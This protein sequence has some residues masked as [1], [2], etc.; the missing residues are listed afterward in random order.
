MRCVAFLIALSLTSPALAE[1]REVEDTVTLNGKKTQ[2]WRGF[3]SNGTPWYVHYWRGGKKVGVHVDFFEDGGRRSE[4][5]YRGDILNGPFKTWHPTGKLAAQGIHRD[6]A[7]DGL[8]EAF[9]LDGEPAE[10]RT[11]ADTLPDGP[12]LAWHP[13]GSK[14]FEG[15]FAKGIPVGAWQHWSP[16]GRLIAERRF[17]AG[18]L[19]EAPGP[20]RATGGLL[21]APDFALFLVTGS[22][23]EGY[24]FQVWLHP[25]GAVDLLT[26]R[27][28]P[29]VAKE[30]TE[31]LKKGTFYSDTRGWH[32]R[33]RLTDADQIAL[34]NQLQRLG[35]F[36][37]PPKVIN[38]NV[39]DGTQWHFGIRAAGKA[40][41]VDC[42]NDFPPALKRFG[43][44]L[45][46]RL[47][48]D[49]YAFER[50]TARPD[51]ERTWRRTFDWAF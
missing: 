43:G 2:R 24:D 36:E 23:L 18:A 9:H 28:V 15:A 46:E 41:R 21:D 35:P 51:A 45:R 22:A 40:H 14:R 26:L 33:I 11:Y 16:E 12:Y 8:Y 38:P 42:S 32:A 1:R 20:I 37:L 25:N 27:H 39:H 47:L 17:E 10:R 29:R 34:A 48:S 30:T 7:K 19:V 44:W 49:D 4:V 50:L 13:N 5:T 6:G 31:G 3:H